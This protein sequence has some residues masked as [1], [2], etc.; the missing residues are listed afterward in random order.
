MFAILVLSRPAILVRSR[1]AIMIVVIFLLGIVWTIVAF[2]VAIVCRTSGGRI[3][4]RRY[5]PGRAASADGI[6]GPSRT[7]S[8]VGIAAG[9][10]ATVWMFSITMRVTDVS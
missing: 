6:T 9:G 2:V 3:A 7:S 4:A 8:A 10:I 1:P 5:M